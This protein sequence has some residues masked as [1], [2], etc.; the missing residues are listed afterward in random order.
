M[1]E[2]VSDTMALVLYLER[3][4]MPEKAKGLFQKADIGEIHI[5]IPSMV[6][7]E[8]GY[9]SS[10]GRIEL[11]IEKIEKYLLDNN[12][13]SVYSQ[14]LEVVKSAFEIH[15]VP[16][17]HDRLIAGTAKLIKAKVITND[18]KIESSIYVETVWK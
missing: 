15:D 10:K 13:Y 12:R 14:S 3:R 18:P 2:Y 17:L 16:E 11:S 1:E 6:I 4:K 5:H 7:A 9:L 8:I